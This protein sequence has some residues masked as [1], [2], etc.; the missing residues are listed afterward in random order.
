MTDGAPIGESSNRSFYNVDSK[1][2]DRQR[3]ASK[4]G[5]FTNRAQQLILQSLCADW[6]NGSIL[7]VGSGTA[8]FSIPLLQKHNRLTLADI[9]PQMLAEARQKI[10][11]AGAGD[12]VEAYVEGSIYELPFEDNSFDHT[13]SLNV[14]NHLERPGDALQQLARVTRPGATLLFNHANLHSFYWPAAQGSTAPQGDCASCLFAVG[15]PDGNAALDRR[16]GIRVRAAGWACSRAACVVQ[17]SGAASGL[18]PRPCFPPR[19]SSPIRAISVLSLSQAPMS[20]KNGAV[21]AFF[22]HERSRHAVR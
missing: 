3:W 2:Y 20:D 19:A 15:T 11:E 18:Y 5:A 9:S 8:R 6:Q 1:T 16:G 4:G 22:G 12:G 13:I 17:I 10:V 21:A 14:F 7:E